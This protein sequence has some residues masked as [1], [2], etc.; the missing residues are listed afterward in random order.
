VLDNMTILHTERLRLEPITDRH[1]GGMRRMTADPEVMHFLNKGK[2]QTEEETRAG[3]ER[4]KRRWEEWGYSWWALIE[5]A[6][7]EMIGAA[8]LQHLGTDAA[9][10]FEIGWRLTRDSWGKGYASE[11]AC[12]IVRHA[13]DTVGA[14]EVLAVAHPDNAA[15][16]KV[17]QRLGM[18]YVGI[19]TH[20]DMPCVVYRL[21]RTAVRD[22]I[23]P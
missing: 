13:F 23:I 18:H 17:M 19:E 10:P 1:Y 3:I 6:S 9:Q 12:A 2:P 22:G 14:D 11:A 7:G 8:C 16:I 4:I 5:T 21:L 20:Y 15:S